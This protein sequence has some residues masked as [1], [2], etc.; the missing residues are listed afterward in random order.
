[1]QCLVNFKVNL[2]LEVPFLFLLFLVKGREQLGAYLPKFAVVLFS[3]KL[4]NPAKEISFF[5]YGAEKDCLI[6]EKIE[7]DQNTY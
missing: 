2:Y 3:F 1:M 5:A 7:L 4:S 6:S